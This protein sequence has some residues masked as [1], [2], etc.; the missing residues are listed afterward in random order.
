MRDSG[1]SAYDDF[2][3]EVAPKE[4]GE[5]FF[6]PFT[7][8]CL[9]LVLFLFGLASLFSASM[10]EAIRDGYQFWHYLA[11]QSIGAAIGIGLGIGADFLPK[12]ILHRIHFVTMPITW[13]MLALVSRLEGFS[14]LAPVSGALGTLSVLFFIVWA[15]PYVMKKE[16]QGYYL[17]LFFLMMI[18]TM[19]YIGLV[20]GTAWYFL[21]LIITI[22]TAS[23][24]KARKGYLFY[25]FLLGLVILYV[26]L[27]YFP[28]VFRFFVYSSF[29]IGNPDYYD[30]SLLAA[31]MA[32]SDGGITGAGL[33]KG[34][35]KLGLIPSPSKLLIF[36][37]VF[38]ETGIIGLSLILIPL[39][40]LLVVGIRTG[41]RAEK[42]NERTLSSIVYGLT[43]FFVFPFFINI[44]HTLGLL[45][46]SGMMLPFFSYSPAL[47]AIY[48]FVVTVLYRNV[49]RLGRSERDEE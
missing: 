45:P 11:L 25:F 14:F 21:A 27:S 23:V 35:Y 33:G 42:N 36:A 44:L 31:R 46:L 6:S 15:V 38:E 12:R 22:T 49:Y 4:T 19:F 37:T 16:R 3:Y 39:I 5:G 43:V 8:L 28:S 32:I 41:N 1:I 20:S 40:L 7:F 48:S 24:M 2:S 9:V 30:P 47:E 18:V 29:P 10:N 13:V 26:L 17:L 34:L